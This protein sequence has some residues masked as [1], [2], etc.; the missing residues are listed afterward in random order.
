VYFKVIRSVDYFVRLP[1]GDLVEN[2]QLLLG[3]RSKKQIFFLSASPHRM[4][5]AVSQGFAVIPI[6]PCQIFLPGDYHL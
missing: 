2:L 4:M 3:N 5:T 1:N 6:V